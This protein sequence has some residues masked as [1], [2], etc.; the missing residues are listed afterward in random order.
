MLRGMANGK[1]ST[2][3]IK[4][5][6]M[7]RKRAEA[8]TAGLCGRC[9][10][11]R[12]DAGYK[13]CRPCQISINEYRRR[14]HA[15]ARRRA[16]LQNIIE[17]HE[18][19]GDVAREHHLY[20][21][22]AQY[23]QDALHAQAIAAEDRSR[24]SEK[25]AYALSLGGD[26]NAANLLFD[27]ALA[28][29]VDKPAQSAKAVEILLHR[30]RQLW[31]DA[32]TQAALPLLIQAI[33]VAE[34]SGD[35]H[36]RKITNSRMANYLIGLGRL[37]EAERFLHAA[38]EIGLNDT[39][40][41]RATWYT[42][43]AILAAA[44]GNAAE[45]FEYFEGAASAAKEDTDVLHITNV[46][47]AYG[48]WATALGDI[49][50]AKTCYEQ[51]LLVARRYHIVWQIPNICLEYSD[52]LVQ[53]GQPGLAYEYLLNALAYDAHTSITDVL[54]ASFGIPLALYMKDEVTLAKCSQ[55]S[56]VDF[57]FRSGHPGL[58]GLVAPAFAQWHVAYGRKREAQTL[59]HHA[60]ETFHDVECEAQIWTFPIAVARFGLP[61]DS[62]KARRLIEFRAAL[63]C[64]DVANAC[65]QLFD[66]FVAQCRG[67]RL[68]MQSR[69]SEAIRRFEALGWHGYADLGRTLLPM[70]AKISAVIAN[71]A[72]PFADLRLA[73]TARE[74]QVAELVLKGFTNRVIA[75][76]LSIKERTVESHMTS[77]MSHLGVH[78]RH[79]LTDVLEETPGETAV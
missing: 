60:L 6:W 3:A 78:S 33:H 26:P 48:F 38:G 19:A 9:Y 27:Q 56:A 46:W 65:L 44:L 72:R 73:L 16:T 57:A 10:K 43:K 13:V 2:K 14:R 17:K 12:P 53:I 1:P 45:A 7:A 34:S 54:L 59:L 22:A 20:A 15:T 8:A 35:S 28:S 67:Q 69:A 76:K 55:P 52:L 58:I 32:R 63:P 61:S 66:A 71:K 21:D 68:E 51:A 42:Q 4:A 64:P 74:R 5:A 25:L 50:R 36:L 24:I 18:S 31:I 11:I 23:Y 39:A 40:A 49:G 79:Q 62:A 41:I 70:P 77:I 47:T 75:E 30:A 29:Y 37:R